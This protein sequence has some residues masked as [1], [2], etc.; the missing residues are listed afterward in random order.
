MLLTALFVVAIAGSPFRVDRCAVS[1]ALH[2][3]ARFWRYRALFVV[4]IPENV[5]VLQD[6]PCFDVETRVIQDHE[7]QSANLD[8][9]S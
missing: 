1:A 3:V 5:D 7:G 9:R 8:G 4:K 2:F 6:L